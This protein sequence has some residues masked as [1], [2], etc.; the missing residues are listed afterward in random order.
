MLN[1]KNFAL[2][3]QPSS[4]KTKHLKQIRLIAI[5]TLLV[6]PFTTNAQYCASNA[7]STADSKCDLVVLNGDSQNINNNT[8][9]PCQ[10]YS[11]HTG[12]L[13]ADLTQNSGY[14]VSLTNGTCGGNYTRYANAWIDWNQDGDFADAG[15]MLGAGTAGNATAGFVHNINFTVPAGALLGNTT[16][17]VIVKESVNA[18]DPCAIYTWGETEDYTVT[19]LA[20]APMT[21]VSSAASTASTA[22]VE[23]CATNAEII[24]IQVVTTGSA[25]PL[26]ITQLR[27]RTDGSTD[28]VND[29]ANVKVYYTGTNA[30]FSTANYFG[31]AAPAAPGTNVNVNGTQTLATGTNY[32][33]VVYD[34]NV[35]ATVG[36]FLDAKAQRITVGASNHNPA[37]PTPA[38]NREIIDCAR[39]CPTNAVILDEQ[40]EVGPIVGWIPGTTYGSTWNG[41]VLSG[42]LNGW[43]NLVNGLSNV[44]VLDRYVDGLYVGCNVTVS[45]WAR[46][47]YGVTNVEFNMIDDNGVVLATNYQADLSATYT[48]YTH[49]FAATTP[50]MRF[51]LHFFSTGASGIDVAMEDLLI[52]QCCDMPVGLP[53]EMNGFEAQCNEDNIEINWTTISENNNDY[54]TIERSRDGSNFESAAIIDG[55]GNSTSTKE[56]NWIDTNPYSGQAYYRL[57][58][59]D[60]GGTTEFFETKSVNCLENSEISI[61]P[62]PFKDQLNI[63][64]Q[65][66][67]TITLTD[68]TGKV[69][70]EQRIDAGD[71][72]I[73]IADLASG[74]YIA[75]VSLA[76]GD[77]QDLKL[78]K[79]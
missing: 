66:S 32:F 24:G 59:T 31:A 9:G 44:D 65:L 6:L 51:V 11:N 7:T 75:N 15:E 10:T 41:M 17:R 38:G 13:P 68:L 18:A 48:Q 77:T 78:V 35:A 26:D 37:S 33:W 71:T 79:L 74:S 23:N 30:T 49:T 40:F 4:G 34:V 57:S 70:L 64:S 25:N 1:L 62:N 50:G 16:M 3:V 5:F 73:E 20:D 8:A 53:V 42:A 21:Y 55:N 45:Y 29:I 14:T 47:S 46:K 28:P 54:F 39:A 72:N 60:F 63:R 2:R 76:N 69:V 58:Q 19:I 56:Y 61:Y 67:G 36:N 43:F 27:L 52:T 22:D 12:L